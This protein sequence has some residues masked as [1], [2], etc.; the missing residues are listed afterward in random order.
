MPNHFARWNLSSQLL[1][2]LNQYEGT[3]ERKIRNLAIWAKTIVEETAMVVSAE[4]NLCSPLLG[5][6]KKRP[7]LWLSRDRISDVCYWLI[8]GGIDFLCSDEEDKS[9]FYVQPLLTLKMA[10]SENTVGTP[11][12]KNYSLAV[13]VSSKGWWGG[14]GGGGS[15]LSSC[16]QREQKRNWYSLRV[17]LR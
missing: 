16:K 5:C 11:I 14:G 4:P 7:P 3:S 12:Y 9:C 10:G 1:L 13:T 2:R 15:R 8:V 6:Y 17:F